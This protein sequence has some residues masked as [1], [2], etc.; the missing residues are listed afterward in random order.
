MTKQV[1]P[2]RNDKLYDIANGE[3][4]P[5]D[6]VKCG[7]RKDLFKSQRRHVKQ[8]LGEDFFHGKLGRVEACMRC[9]VGWFH[10]EN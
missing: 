3:L 7:N 5:G 9:G 2:I 4:P 6:T 1:P 10:A 8:D